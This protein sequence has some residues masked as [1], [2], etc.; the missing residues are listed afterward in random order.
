M[1]GRSF[2]F[3]VHLQSH[4]WGCLPTNKTKISPNIG[5]ALHAYIPGVLSRAVWQ[6][7]LP[8]LMYLS[9]L[10]SMFSWRSI[11]MHFSLPQGSAESPEVLQWQRRRQGRL[12][13]SSRCPGLGGKTDLG[14]EALHKTTTRQLQDNYKT[15]HKT[16]H[17]TTPNMV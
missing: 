6:Y 1:F 11:C 13:H 5:A 12:S 14:L 8:L 2:G 16:T 3:F 4:V 10:L 17:K 15:T 9:L 7:L